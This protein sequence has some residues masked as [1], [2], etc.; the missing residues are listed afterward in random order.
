MAQINRLPSYNDSNGWWEIAGKAIPSKK[1]SGKEPNVEIQQAGSVLG[2]VRVNTAIIGGGIC[3]LST[4]NRLGELCPSD[5]ICLIEA[6][7]VGHG[8]SGRNAGFLLNLH[9]H[10]PPKDLDTLRQNMQLWGAGLSSLRKKVEAWKIPCDW[11][12]AGRFYGAAGPDGR[13][14]VREITETLDSLGLPYDW[15]DQADLKQRI[16]TEFYS[17][18]IFVPGNALVNPS[19]L[20]RGLAQNLPCNV[21][22]YEKS[23]VTRFERNGEEFQ[24]TTPRGTVIADRLVLASGVYLKDFGIATGRYVPMATY[25]SLSE[26]LSNAEL[27]HLGTGEEFGLLGGS[28]IGSTV[29]LTQ[30]KRIFMRNYVNFEPGKPATK[31]RLKKVVHMHN[32]ALKARWPALK[33]LKF[34]HS[35]GGAMALTTNNGTVF[36]EYEKNLF[37][38]LTNDVS[39]LTRGEATGSL[40]AEYMQGIDS[41]LLSLQQAIP[42]AA[43]LPVRPFLDLGIQFH[44]LYLNHI[45]S[46]EI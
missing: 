23:P 3:G 2:K 43:R 42:Q 33:N 17:E 34:Q 24:I 22:V 7:Y 39:P 29:R 28:Q 13:K 27:A 26:P 41:D 30:D 16:G 11:N 1:F 45:A 15:K 40:L 44:K 31:A 4:A 5:E 9:S 18:G 21:N 20:M 38:I 19:S 14:H 12:D 37:A 8:V 6:D 46:K 10:G 35:W 36:G 32:Q 25:A